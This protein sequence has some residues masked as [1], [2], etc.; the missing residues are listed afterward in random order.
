MPDIID[1][2]TERERRNG[3][4]EQFMTVDQD[5]RPMF[6]F[7]AE[8]QIDG[9]TFGINFFAYDFA[10]AELRV[11][12]MRASLTVAGQIYAEVPG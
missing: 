5:G 9:G 1:F 8:Y 12:S 7:F 3:P 4:D 2:Q 10:D 6:A 11:S